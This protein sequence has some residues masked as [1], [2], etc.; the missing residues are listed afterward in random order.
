VWH[1]FAP[2]EKARQ[3]RYTQ[4]YPLVMRLGGKVRGR[5]EERG[6]YPDTLPTGNVERKMCNSVRSTFIK[7]DEE[8]EM[9]R[10]VRGGKM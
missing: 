1:E 6:M 3:G 2:W 9:K 10:E 7:F 5:A 8:M 4:V